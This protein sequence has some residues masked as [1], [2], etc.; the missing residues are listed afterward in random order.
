MK[1]RLSVFQVKEM[2]STDRLHASPCYAVL[3]LH[4]PKDNTALRIIFT[5]GPRLCPAPLQSAVRYHLTY[6]VLDPAGVFQL[7]DVSSLDFS[8]V[9]LRGFLNR[10][11]SRLSPWLLPLSWP[12]ELPANQTPYQLSFTTTPQAV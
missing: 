11:I 2:G 1:W 9:S 3:P 6:R 8:E 12:L 10:R 4:R 5:R 7:A